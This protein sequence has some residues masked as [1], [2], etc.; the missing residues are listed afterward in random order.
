MQVPVR[1]PLDL[2]DWLKGRGPV[3]PQLVEGAR[4]IRDDVL[5]TEARDRD[6]R[7][8]PPSDLT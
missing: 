8:H 3:A 5:T 4:Q 6:Y 2:Y 7:F 1:V